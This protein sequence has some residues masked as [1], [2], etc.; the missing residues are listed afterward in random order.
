M[1]LLWL[2]VSAEERLADPN[3][4]RT[5]SDDD[6]AAILEGVAMVS[7]VGIVRQLAELSE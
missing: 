7:M 4:F 1:P 2:E 6:P 5:A 3:L